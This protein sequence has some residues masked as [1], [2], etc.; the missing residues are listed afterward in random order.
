MN[1]SAV[2]FITR[3]L[4][5]PFGLNLARAAITTALLWLLMPFTRREKRLQKKDFGRLLLCSLTG[6]V[7]NQLLFIKG[8]SMTFSM[9]AALLVLITP[10]LITIFA[11]VIGNER[12]SFSAWSGLALG[13][14]GALMLI[15]NGTNKGQAGNVFWG[16]IFVV[17]N[18]FSY[19]I[20][21]VLVKPLMKEYHA[22]QIL[23][24][25]FTIGTFFTAIFGWREFNAINWPEFTRFDFLVF[26]FILIC[27]TFFAY[28]FTI[29]GISILGASITGSYIYTQPVFAS[30]I[31]L[32]FLGEELFPYK[33]I[34]ALLI[35]AG[36]FLV[37]RKKQPQG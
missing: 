21:F 10:I 25:I 9:H 4:V 18:S 2:Q 6:I 1:Y 35:T 22:V 19:A 32:I 24:W 23:R 17:I 30:V 15:L 13:I 36:V 29:Y 11:S 7:F 12:M 26:F 3:K 37:S 8:L 20:Y 31:A 16:D 27:A 34:A 33:V 28:L 14:G 5:Q